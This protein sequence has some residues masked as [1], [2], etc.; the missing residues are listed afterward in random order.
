MTVREFLELFIDE[1][2][3]YFEVYDNTKDETV[4]KGYLEELSEDLE[5]ATVS[6]IDNIYECDNAKGITINIDME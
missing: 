3:Q 6:S 2:S 4:F 5:Y 1:D